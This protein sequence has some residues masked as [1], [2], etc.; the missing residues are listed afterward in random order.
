MLPCFFV[1]WLRLAAT[2]TTAPA[3]LTKTPLT[4]TDGPTATVQVTGSTVAPNEVTTTT[5]MPL[6]ITT[7]VTTLGPSKFAVSP[8]ATA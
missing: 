5:Q 7:N 8:P 6:A 1:L 2:S 3:N 4:V